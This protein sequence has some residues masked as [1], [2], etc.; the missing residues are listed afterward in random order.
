V[1]VPAAEARPAKP[2][3]PKALRHPPRVLSGIQPTLHLHLGHYLGAIRHQI[4]L[5]HEYPFRSF[6]LI[7]DY[8]AL[9][10][11]LPPTEVRNGVV[12]VATAFLAFGLDPVKAYLFRQSDVPAICELAWILSTFT[13]FGSVGRMP[14]FKTRE[15]EQTAALL[16][17]PILQAA[18]ILSMRATIIP[19]GRDQKLHI[20]LTEKLAERFNKHVH[21]A[22]FPI[23]KSRLS[24][25]GTVKGTDGKKMHTGAGNQI[26]LFRR[27]DYIKD[28]VNAIE[29][30]PVRRG[31]L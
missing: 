19:A 29:T 25:T 16:Q 14:T 4:D 3:A 11:R 9:V 22:V 7:A 6:C 10:R 15:D 31:D 23:P 8:H 26:E 17:Y 1:E 20:E 27:Y 28:R 18:D 30:K 5:H 21:R 12:A 2:A 13:P 24:A